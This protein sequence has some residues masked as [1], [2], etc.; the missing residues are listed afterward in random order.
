MSKF[1]IIE[2]FPFPIRPT[3]SGPF[4]SS[5]RNAPIPPYLI[6]QYAGKQWTSHE[7]RQSVAAV[8][9]LLRS[10]KG[11]L[12]IDAANLILLLHGKVYEDY[13][14]N[15]VTGIVSRSALTELQNAV[16]ARMLEL[17]IQLEK[18]IPAAAEIT[19][20]P[21]AKAP[22]A[23]DKDTVTQITQQII[24]GNVTTISSSG[25]GAHIQINIVEGDGESFVKALVRAGITKS[26][27]HQLAK[28]VASEKGESRE[29]PFGTK[30]KAWIATE[31]A[32]KYYGF[33]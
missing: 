29:E 5:I 22:A 24:H 12:Q 28:I 16:R 4:Q 1:R 15:S 8:D 31:A 13:A 6:E 2:N 32:L 27:A 26:D 19:V 33:K 3:F 21:I 7:M 9:D 25:E 10:G 30:A 11:N 20:G 17:T 14:C 23:K 18:S